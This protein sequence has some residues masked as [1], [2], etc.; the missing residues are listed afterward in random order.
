MKKAKY[1]IA[2][3]LP[4]I[5]WEGTSHDEVAKGQKVTSA[6]FCF[7]SFD[8]EQEEWVAKC[9]G[10]SISLGIK[11]NPFEDELKFRYALNN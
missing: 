10:E 8:A 4:I 11:S 7:I 3:G 9:F 2:N 6:G 5:F 1:V